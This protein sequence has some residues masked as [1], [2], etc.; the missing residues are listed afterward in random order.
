MT[1]AD[2]ADI[3]A[4]AISQGAFGNFVLLTKRDRRWPFEEAKCRLHAPLGYVERM[5]RSFGPKHDWLAFF[6][7]EPSTAL[8]VR[9]T[10][11]THRAS[12]RQ[13]PYCPAEAR[14]MGQLL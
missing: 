6:R 12:T 14:A 7:E 1:L 8:P 10:F 5:P 9:R 3:N 13:L 2:G 11:Q 4:P